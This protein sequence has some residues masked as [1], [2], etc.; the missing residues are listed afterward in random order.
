MTLLHVDIT[1][2]ACKQALLSIANGQVY[3]DEVKVF[4]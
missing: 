4:L 1:I 2:L 3:P